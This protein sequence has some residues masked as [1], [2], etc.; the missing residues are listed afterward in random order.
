MKLSKRLLAIGELVPKNSIVADIGTDHGYIP[1]YL[2]ENNIS[3]K[4]IGTDISKGSL[5]KIIKYIKDSGHEKKIDSRLGYGLEVIKPYEVDTVVIAGMGG[6]LINEIL[7]KDKTITESITNFILQPMLGA[8]EL[9]I[10]LMENN[11]QIIKEELVKDEGK[12]YEIIFAKKG[13]GYIEEDIHYEIAEELIKEN[14]PILKEF[15]YNK[16]F[17]AQRIINDL[18]GKESE[19]VKE[20]YD[21]LSNLIN[22]YKDVLNKIES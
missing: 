9:R 7:D 13:K 21:E 2:I 5:D 10:Y 20:R 18:E 19:K 1:A 22:Q 4:V 8:K 14:H 11:F 16:I 3:K 6:I 15:L 17:L 12:Y